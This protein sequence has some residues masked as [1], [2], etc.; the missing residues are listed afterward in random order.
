MLEGSNE[1]IRLQREATQQALDAIRA[2][3]ASQNR[4]GFGAW[5][6]DVIMNFIEDNMPIMCMGVGKMSVETKTYNLYCE[7]GEKDYTIV[8]R[9]HTEDGWQVHERTIKFKEGE[10][11]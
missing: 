8:I 6:D 5:A 9:S 10:K 3:K 4:L 1:H 2:S 7:Y 11:K